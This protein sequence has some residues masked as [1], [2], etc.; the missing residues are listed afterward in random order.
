MMR[1]ATGTRRRGVA[2]AAAVGLFAA[3]CGTSVVSGPVARITTAHAVGDA[4]AAL[5]HQ[6]GITA[7]LSLGLDAEQVGRLGA[8]GHSAPVNPRVAAAI[9]T[10]RIVVD[11]DSTDGA[12]LSAL[13]S[14]KAGTQTSTE[15]HLQVGATAPLDVRSVGGALYARVQLRDLV[16]A[17]GGSAA[18]AARAVGAIDRA[19]RVLPGAAAFAAGDW[20]RIDLAALRR[21]GQQD[22]GGLP[23]A[24]QAQAKALGKKLV[25]DLPSAVHDALAHHT[26]FTNLGDHG[27]RTEYSASIASRA[28]VDELLRTA[29]ADLRTVPSLRLLLAHVPTTVD[30]IPAT[31][32]T[33]LQLWVLDN[34]IEEIDLDLAQFD[35]HL[36]FPVPLRLVIGAGTPV[37]AP[38]HATTVDPSALLKGFA[39][40]AGGAFSAGPST[41]A[42]TP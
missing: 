15:L 13:L 7:T 27:G 36:P 8:L 21:L 11:V 26:T 1:W 25:H 5:G 37:V 22:A 10:T 19:E 17:F 9:A 41:G 4:F 18:S 16:S 31:Q 40:R 6:R 2:L 12:S 20:V 28:A 34:R 32:H 14:S 30:A 33:V 42:V 38:G 35:H 39:A 23:A 29:V 24:Q 3:G